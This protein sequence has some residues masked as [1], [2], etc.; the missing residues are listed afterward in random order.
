MKMWLRL[1]ILMMILCAM[2]C[3]SPWRRLASIPDKEGFAGA[4]AGVSEGRLLVAGGANFPDRKPW[5]GG[6]KIWHDSVFTLDHPQGRWNLAGRL[7]RPLG[8]GVSVTWGDGILCFG[9]SDADRHYADGFR[10]QIQSGKLVT[11]PLPP[12]PIPIANGCGALVGDTLYIAGGLER[13]DS[14]RTLHKA[15]ALNLNETGAGWKAIEPWPGPGR[16]LAVA[17]GHDGA[18]WLIG[19]VDLQAGSDGK[20]ARKYLKD[21]YRYEPGK[22]WSRIADLPHPV[23]AAPSPAA[24]DHRGPLI[25]GGDDGSQVDRP[26]GAHRGFS[27]IVLGYDRTMDRWKPVGELPAP[28]VTVPLVVWRNEWVIP[29][30]EARPGIRSPEVWSLNAER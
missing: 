20:I 22:G 10:L 23:A 24:G 6:R 16:M 5:E 21:A 3:E 17:A 8:Y 18:F 2:G 30:G 9:G 14:A 28:R 15:F 26:P 13:P 19:G 29:S 7:P 12:L 1:M 4:F 25:F 11:H 27:K